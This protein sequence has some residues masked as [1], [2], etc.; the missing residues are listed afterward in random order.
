MFVASGGGEQSGSR[1]QDILEFIEDLLG[2]A[3]EDAVAV[4]WMR[5]WMRI[6]VAGDREG[7]RH[8]MFLR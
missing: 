6:T 5:A 1:V 7:Q 4:V 2:G 3:V 8:A